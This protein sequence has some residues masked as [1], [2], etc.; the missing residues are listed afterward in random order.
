MITSNL[1]DLKYGIIYFYC[2]Q[3][4]SGALQ[5]AADL[6]RR[7]VFPMDIQWVDH[8]DSDGCVIVARR[9]NVSN[10]GR[11]AIVRLKVEDD[12]MLGTLYE[13]IEAFARVLLDM[14]DRRVGDVQLRTSDYGP[15]IMASE[16][17]C[18]YL[19]EAA[20]QDHTRVKKSKP[21]LW[22][23]L[24]K[25][26]M[27]L[28]EE[29][30]D[31]ELTDGATSSSVPRSLN[32]EREVYVEC[33][34]EAAPQDLLEE[35]EEDLEFKRLERE[36]KQALERIR[37]D[38]VAYVARYHEDPKELMAE[39]LQGK[40]V[41][42]QPGR[43]LVNGDM[44]IVLPEY[45]EMEIEMPASCRTLYILF[46][47]LRKQG[48]GIIL[49]NIDEHREELLAIYTMVKPGASDERARKTVGNLCDPLCDSLNQTIS[50]INRC[51]RDVI[52]DAELVKRYI[53][54]GKKGEPYSIALDPQYLE[55]PRAVTGT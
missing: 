14:S 25:K 23:S 19:P 6:L 45:D 35:L 52:T 34:D 54:T 20:P 31:E 47:K 7:L 11:Y 16:S 29:E 53:V 46:M 42:G 41:V 13:A 49:K 48:R 32:L 27:D 4:R 1:Q 15:R 17:Y 51:I 8:P 36:R 26:L 5:Q 33:G 3:K 50:R 10:I 12:R 24:K 18:D 43:L 21:R 55:L 22:K 30:L 37:R 9:F 38:I 44:K 40:V 28:V 39:L 2:N